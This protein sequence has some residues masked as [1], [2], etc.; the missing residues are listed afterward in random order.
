MDEESDYRNLTNPSVKNTYRAF[1]GSYKVYEIEIT[2]N[3]LEESETIQKSLIICTN[4]WLL[5][6]Y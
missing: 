5:L 4:L 2:I 3:E 6:S 1:S